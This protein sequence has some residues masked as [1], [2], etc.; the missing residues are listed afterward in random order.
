M[1]LLFCKDC[2]DVV[3]LQL[4]D[5]SCACGNSSGRYNADGDTCTVSGVSAVVIAIGN[6]SLFLG[7]LMQPETGEG[8]NL[9]AW[10]FAKDYH[11]INHVKH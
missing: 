10:V 2:S 8:P 1:K 9:K 5:R 11:K 6:R 7:V 3:K 4:F